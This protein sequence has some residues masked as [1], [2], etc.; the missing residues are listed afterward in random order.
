MKNPMQTLPVVPA[1][2]S[3]PYG[4]NR[5]PRPLTRDEY[6]AREHAMRLALETLRA[7]ARGHVEEAEG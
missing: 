4:Y 5:E 6:Q 7:R 1:N 2:T 3:S